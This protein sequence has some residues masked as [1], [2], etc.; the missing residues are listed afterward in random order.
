MVFPENVVL[1]LIAKRKE[2]ILNWLSS[3]DFNGRHSVIGESHGEQTG[4]WLLEELT[5]WFS[6]SGPRIVI[7]KGPGINFVNDFAEI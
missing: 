4:V 5:K 6:G 1:T 2:D 7:C 3:G